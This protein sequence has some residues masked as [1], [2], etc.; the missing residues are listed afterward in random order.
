MTDRMV[1]KVAWMYAVY[2]W[3]IKPT[4]GLTL[5]GLSQSQQYE[6]TDMASAVLDACHF[7]ELVKALE[8]LSNELAPWLT[9]ADAG[10]PAVVKTL[11]DS[12]ALHTARRKASALLA[13]VKERNGHD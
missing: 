2:R 10:L 7:E 1:E 9:T 11:G 4:I 5:K 8:T 12:A 6:A 3:R 13:K